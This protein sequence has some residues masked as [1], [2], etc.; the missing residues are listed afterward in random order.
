MKNLATFVGV[1]LTAALIGCATQKTAVS[2]GAVEGSS[3]KCCA[4]QASPGAVGEKNC[5]ASCA[6]QCPAKSGEQVSPGTVG[7]GAAK[8]G[9]CKSKSTSG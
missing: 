1:C 2:P 7:D 3:T 5:A 8:T 9:C 4:S 6:K